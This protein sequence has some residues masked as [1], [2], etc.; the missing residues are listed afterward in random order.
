MCG[1][2]KQQLK[3]DT[4]ES[5]DSIK[6]MIQTVYSKYGGID[7]LVNGAYKFIEKRIDDATSEDFDETLKIDVTGYFLVSQLATQLMKQKKQVL[8]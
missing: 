6:K 8:S 5:E 4:A 7:I 2:R 1:M 3:V